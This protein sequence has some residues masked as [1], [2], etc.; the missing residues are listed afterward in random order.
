[1]EPVHRCDDCGL[2]EPLDPEVVAAFALT[3]GQWAVLH[4]WA[5]ASRYYRRQMGEAFD[6][7][8]EVAFIHWLREEQRLRGQLRGDQRT[9]M[10]A[11]ALKRGRLRLAVG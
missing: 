7:D 3:E 6:V 5:R 1:M 11:S 9:N 8:D 4:Q 2:P 10:S